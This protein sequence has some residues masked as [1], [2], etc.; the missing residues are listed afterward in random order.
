MK[1]IIQITLFGFAFGALLILLDKSELNEQRSSHSLFP[2]RQD[3]EAS[4]SVGVDE[5]L[6]QNAANADGE[7]NGVSKIVALI[8]DRDKAYVPRYR[9]IANLRLVNLDSQDLNKLLV[10]MKN[11]E[12]LSLN[13]AEI[14]LMNFVFQKF[15]DDEFLAESALD[16][17]EAIALDD[18]Q[19]PLWREYVLQY[20]DRILFWHQDSARYG[21]EQKRVMDVLSLALTQ[22]DLG[23][24]GTALLAKRRIVRDEIAE[25]D[26]AAVIELATTWIVDENVALQNRISA[27]QVL[28]SFGSDGDFEAA[29]S[30]LGGSHE[31]FN[32]INRYE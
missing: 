24:A 9:A 4:N 18:R 3:L 32:M 11:P 6:L 13:E 29:V 19:D 26:E 1:I 15:V 23:I 12:S 31:I 7:I 8:A 28:K 14:S 5:E 10:F 20:A 27:L 2:E 21:V 25:V 17:I 22:T 16:V 30:M